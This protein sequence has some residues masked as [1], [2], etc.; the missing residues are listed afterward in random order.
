MICDRDTQITQGKNENKLVPQQLDINKPKKKEKKEKEL[1]LNTIHNSIY[2]INPD[3]IQELSGKHELV[4]HFRK[5][6]KK[7]S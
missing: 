2:K 3:W 6:R 5:Y 1:E 7:T 4:K